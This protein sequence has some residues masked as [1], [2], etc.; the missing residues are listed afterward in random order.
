[1]I[2]RKSDFALIKASWSD[3]A[4]AVAEIARELNI[5]VDSLVF[6]DDNPKERELVRTSHPDVLVPELPSSEQMWVEFLKDL[7]LFTGAS[8]TE[9]DSRR[10]ELLRYQETERR[11][12]GRFDSLINTTAV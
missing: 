7:G 4:K 8:L 3:K 11:I 1:M 9:E 2:L 5:G 10:S 12:P 6:I